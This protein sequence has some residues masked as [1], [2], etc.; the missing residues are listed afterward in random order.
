MKPAAVDVGERSPLRLVILASTLGTVFEWYDFFVYGTLAGVIGQNFFPAGNS[1]VSLLITLATFGVGFGMRPIGAALFG[2]L[3][4][5]LGRKYT[6]LVTVTVMGGATAG[7]GLLPTYAS[8]GFAAPLLLVLLRVAQGLA[9]GGEYGGAAIY[10]AEHAPRKRRG[11]YTSF[12]QA[13][14]AGGFLLSLGVVV[15]AS[16]FVAKDDWASWGWRIPF[17]FSLVL[18]A[19]SLWIRMM[20]RE[21]PIFRAM[22]IEGKIAQNPLKES[23]DSWPKWRKL[24]VVLFGIT[25]GLTVIFYTA[26]FQSLYFIQN[27]V[28]I[29]DT[30][31]RLIV[32]FSAFLSIGWYV[33]FGWLSDKI[34]RKPPIIAGYVL[35]LVLA[36]PLFKMMSANGNPDLA[37]AFGRA[38]VVVRGSDCTFNPLA[39]HGQSRACGRVLDS[40]SKRGIAYKKVGIAEGPPMVTIGSKVLS[41]PDDKAIE[42]ALAAA[43]YP[44]GKVTPTLPR[45][46]KV[47][48]GII[49][50]AFISG[51]TYGPVAALLVELFPA[52]VRYTSLSIPYHIGA[53]YFGG[54]LPFI[55]QYIVAKTGD[56]LAGLWYTVG[57]TAVALLIVS[58]AL[59]ETSG[60]E[61]E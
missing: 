31:A 36:F 27:A 8:I 19:I 16:D 43:G 41:A 40:L 30:P 18:L 55:N 21:S 28:R 1:A 7:V 2:V 23:V 11:L 32:G 12:I 42:A 54:F 46:M 29:D 58:L 26:H 48:F 24:L 6:F 10:V 25:A 39:A 5:K 49:V 38:P 17:L 34:G 47:A 59:P 53:G 3:G 22:Q 14:A 15:V 33:L 9:L 51:M 45:A 44:T 4:D 37:A 50:I 20:L 35:M 61:L 56:P 52:R 13:G 57:V 60:K